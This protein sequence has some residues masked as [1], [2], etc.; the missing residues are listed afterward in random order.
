MILKKR[1][2]SEKKIK[3]N[4][5]EASNNSENN[6]EDDF[7]NNA[8]LE[9]ESILFQEEDKTNNAFL[10]LQNGIKIPVKAYGVRGIFSGFISFISGDFS[11]EK[12]Q[13]INNSHRIFITDN[14]DVYFGKV[15]NNKHI[16][17]FGI[18]FIPNEDENTLQ[19][20]K[21]NRDNSNKTSNFDLLCKTKNITLVRNFQQ[22]QISYALKNN[23]EYIKFQG[24]KCLLYFPDDLNSLDGDKETIDETLNNLPNRINEFNFFQHYICEHP[25]FCKG[26]NSENFNNLYNIS[27]LK[28]KRKKVAVINFG[29]S[30]N[31]KN[32]LQQYFE[33][34]IL[35][36]TE[37]ATRLEYLN[38]DGIIFSD[39]ICDT[40]FLKEE[41][42]NEIK[43]ILKI[44]CPILGFEFG[45]ILIA[46]NFGCNIDYDN[47]IINYEQ[48]DIHSRLNKIFNVSNFYYKKILSLS[49]GL[50]PLYYNFNNEEIVGFGKDN[51][52]GYNF[53]FTFNNSDVAILLNNFYKLTNEFK[54]KK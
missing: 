23:E 28:N 51:I 5:V 7:S 29:I 12:I 35:P 45:A 47:N 4:Q 3:K 20:D 26:K 30:N 14:S 39:S 6:C 13:E 10:F 38:I 31:L 41:I 16:I 25:Y 53:S 34:I 27:I 9:Q 48:Y 22:E 19:E 2:S 52:I 54:Y 36:M 49:N 33:L 8:I 11:I 37:T 17:C 24:N 46:E 50:N 40:K 1:K 18:N 15:K 21:N 32:I 44:R 43:K 42:K